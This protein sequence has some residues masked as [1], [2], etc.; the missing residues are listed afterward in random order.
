[1][2]AQ[3]MHGIEGHPL[4]EYAVR[5]GLMKALEKDGEG[6]YVNN[7]DGNLY[8]GLMIKVEGGGKFNEELFGEASAWFGEIEEEVKAGDVSQF[9]GVGSTPLDLYKKR[10]AERIRG[11]RHDPAECWRVFDWGLRRVCAIDGAELWDMSPDQLF[12]YKSLEGPQTVPVTG[13][14]SSVI[15]S[16]VKE[17]PADTLWTNK[18]VEKIEYGLAEPD[19]PCCVTVGGDEPRKIHAR[20]VISTV[21]LGVLQSGI[22]QFEPPLPREKSV[23]ISRMGIGKIE[24]LFFEFGDDD[25]EA[26]SKLGFSPS[27]TVTLTDQ[28]AP[29]TS[30][31]TGRILGLNRTPGT[32]YM[33]IWAT[34]PA[35]CEHV[36]SASEVSL[37]DDLAKFMASL[38]E[39]GAAIPRAKSV[40]RTTWSKNKYT[41]GS[42]SYLAAESC[43]EDIEVLGQPLQNLLFAGEASHLCFYGTVHGAYM[44]GEREA[45]RILKG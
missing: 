7:P 15:S 24:K 19:M 10:F 4:Y 29:P 20:Y 31:W 30:K 33:A 9:S 14:Y 36:V 22:I 35:A 28:E 26:L 43:K 13:G 1:M 6:E 38:C 23:A 34:S 18:P 2:G 40:V 27:M 21:S 44:T 3:W 39:E 16:L 41:M 25:W 11:S 45:E 17:L 32:R 12:E 37:V 8:S 42:W 5:K